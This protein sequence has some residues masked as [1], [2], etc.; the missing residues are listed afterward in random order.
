ML[1]LDARAARYTWTAAVVLLSIGGV[2]LLRHTLFIFVIALLFAYL[3]SPLV[4]LIDRSMPTRS[5]TAA[6]A[7]TYVVFVALLV[8]FGFFIGSR[9]A[10]Q[11]AALTQ[12]LP[13]L[14]ASLS[15]PAPVPLPEAVQSLKQQVVGKIQ[16]LVREHYNDI[17]AQVPKL[18]LKVLAAAG[19]LIYVVIVPILA[20]F[21]LK[22]ARHIRA[23][24]LGYF[25]DGPHRL[26]I[27][28][29]LADFHVLLAQYMRALMIL[30][31]A[32][33]VFYSIFFSIMG[34][35]YGILLAAIA[36]P[37][38]FI[39]MIGPLSA[40]IIILVVAGAT[41]SSLWPILLFLIAYRLFQDYVL[42]PHLMSSGV[43]LHPLLVI[44]GV[45]A[46]EELA[47]IAGAFLSVPVLALLRVFYIRIE[48]LRTARREETVSP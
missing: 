13:D 44:F 18:S 33:F 43:E 16:D 12:K 32:T 25:E 10:E 34:V 22:D 29:M 47:G 5:R 9:V 11:A 8:L 14:A 15:K 31:F 38:E 19:N 42:Q 35:Q 41:G 45:F 30:C 23:G 6:L 26:L 21:F 40:A 39:P 27:Q 1:G 17:L 36:F 4:N 24:I 28:G 3:L 20:F 2:Y 37:L 7:I 48:R 46:G